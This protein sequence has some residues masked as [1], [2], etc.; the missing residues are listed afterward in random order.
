MFGVHKITGVNFFILLYPF[1][2][3]L[4]YKK[5]GYIGLIIVKLYISYNFYKFYK[6]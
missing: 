5:S 3:K 1:Q 4:L 2:L 6:M